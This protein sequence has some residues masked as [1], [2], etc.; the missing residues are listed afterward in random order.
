MT[1]T[2]KMVFTGDYCN[3]SAASPTLNEELLEIFRS[4]DCLCVNLEVPILPKEHSYKPSLKVGP[5]LS[6]PPESIELLRAWGA[7]HYSAANNHIMDYGRAGLEST[8]NYVDRDNCIGIGLDFASA[9]ESHF[10]CLKNKQIALLSF[11]EAQFGV[12]QGNENNQVA[13]FAWIGHPLARDRIRTAHEI[14]DYVIVQV[15]AGLEM[16][17]LPLP[18]W[19]TCYRELIDLGADL[20]IAHHPHVIQG[21]EEYNGKMIYYSLGNFFIDT[22]LKEGSGG[23]VCVTLGDTGGMQSEYIP[24]K[25]TIDRIGL[26]REGVGMKIYQESCKTLEDDA[27]Y[28]PKITSI[29]KQYWD[30][31][32]L[33]HYQSSLYGV[34]LEV[35][36]RSI[37]RWLRRLIRS[38][39]RGTISSDNNIALLIHNIRI[40]TNRWVVERAF[41]SKF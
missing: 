31:T 12:L 23:I 36:S 35:N 1:D 16:T 9:Y 21:S 20:V 28:L 22:M 6:Q 15:H 38:F 5:R 37:V 41:K 7:T 8:F 19:R 29:C 10:V 27:E 14:S 40:E 24:L 3:T 4:A 39:V 13:G 17:N 32:Y 18:E 25:A 30:K 2:V 11:A 26:D 34:G 33:D